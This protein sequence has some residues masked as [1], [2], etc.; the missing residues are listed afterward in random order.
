MLYCNYQ[1]VYWTRLVWLGSFNAPS[2]LY[3]KKQT[4]EKLHATNSHNVSSLGSL[5][6]PFLGIC[7]SLFYTTLWL[8]VASLFLRTKPSQDTMDNR[9][10]IVWCF[11]DQ[12]NEE[13]RSKRH[14]SITVNHVQNPFPESTVPDPHPPLFLSD[15]K[16]QTPLADLDFMEGDGAPRSDGEGWGGSSASLLLY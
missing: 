2:T 16:R 10:R 3:N 5:Y 1:S 9:S 8:E 14:T 15:K 12:L 13:E 11:D 4:S 6:F 7:S